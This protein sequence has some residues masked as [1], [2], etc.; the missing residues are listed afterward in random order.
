MLS[1]VDGILVRALPY[2]GA[3]ALVA[4]RA[5]ND[6]RDIR[7]SGLS[8]AD[9]EVWRTRNHTRGKVLVVV[10]GYG[11]SH[12]RWGAAPAIVERTIH[13]NNSSRLVVGIMPASFDFPE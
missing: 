4:I 9:Y 5:R 12:R 3:G 2:R 1:A 8:W 10:L 6:A 7:G 13:I 11:L